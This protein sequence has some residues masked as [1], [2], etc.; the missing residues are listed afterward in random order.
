MGEDHCYVRSCDHEN[1]RCHYT[2]RVSGSRASWPISFDSENNQTILFPQ[3]SG[4]NHSSHRAV[5]IEYGDFEGNMD[6]TE[7]FSY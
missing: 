2:V 5:M 6:H 4:R 1:K 3:R 7:W